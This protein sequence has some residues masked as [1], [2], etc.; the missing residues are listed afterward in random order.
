MTHTA[1]LAYARATGR[2]VHAPTT[3]HCCTTSCPLWEHRPHLQFVCTQHFT[4][5]CCGRGCTRSAPSAGAWTCTLTGR[6]TDALISSVDVKRSPPAESVGQPLHAK[7]HS[8]VSF[9]VSETVRRLFT[10][11]RRTVLRDATRRRAAKGQRVNQPVVRVGMSTGAQPAGPDTARL[12]AQLTKTLITLGGKRDRM[13][14]ETFV[15]GMVEF[16]RT[17][18]EV[19]GIVIIQKDA[20]VAAHAPPDVLT[21]SFLESKARAVT[22]AKKRILAA[23]APGGVPD[24]RHCR[25]AG[26][27][28]LRART[29]RTRLEIVTGQTVAALSAFKEPLGDVRANRLAGAGAR[30][31]HECR[32]RAVREQPAPAAR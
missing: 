16:M 20:Y 30:W 11:H 12:A 8:Q 19:A 2:Q 4:V 31:R 9:R 1:T 24:P 25:S 26:P 14:V 27:A 28:V 21:A 6:D 17:G 7:D 5:H 32:P 23:L 10:S 13:S 29:Q 22:K 18:R 15:A 3:G